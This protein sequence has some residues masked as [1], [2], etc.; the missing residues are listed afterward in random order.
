M[1]ANLLTN[2]FWLASVLVAHAQPRLHQM[3]RSATTTTQ[4]TLMT[5]LLCV[6]SVCVCVCVCVCL[7]VR[8][9][10]CVV[11]VS[12][13]QSCFLLPLHSQPSTPA[14]LRCAPTAVCKAHALATTPALASPACPCRSATLLGSASTAPAPTLQT[15]ALP[16]TTAT[17]GPSTTPAAARAHVLAL[18][19]VTPFS[20]QPSHSATS[21]APARWA[22]ALTRLPPPARRV[23]TAIQ[24]R[25]WTRAT[26]ARVLA[27]ISVPT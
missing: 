26:R 18:T 4:Q 11:S 10:L 24:T 22:C 9:C 14:I 5:G 8:L 20:A 3:E 7:R 21:R 13:S 17:S 25:S 6:V 15:R 2:A 1:C 12:L 27:L 19:P 16:A 23:T